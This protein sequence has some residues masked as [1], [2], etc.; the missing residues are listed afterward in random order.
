MLTLQRT[1][2]IDFVGKMKLWV[3]IS[4]LASLISVVGYFV[5]G[6]NLGIEFTGGTEVQ[7]KFAKTTD[8]GAIRSALTKI[9]LGDSNVQQLGDAGENSFLIHVAN[10]TSNPQ[11]FDAEIK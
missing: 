6:L 2:K 10:T 8:A 11:R 5:N 1:P 9:N 7:V 4:T 3:T